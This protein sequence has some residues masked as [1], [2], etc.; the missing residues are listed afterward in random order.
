MAN[1]SMGVVTFSNSDGS[2][3]PGGNDGTSWPKPDIFIV[4]CDRQVMDVLLKIRLI[5]NAETA[6]TQR[7]RRR[8]LNYFDGIR[9]FILRCD[10]EVRNIL[11][12]M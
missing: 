7:S 12:K 8:N 6:E 2:R 10:R 9:I 5:V 3:L 1:K 4:R 11:P